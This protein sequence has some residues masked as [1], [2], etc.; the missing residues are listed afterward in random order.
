MTEW[1]LD[2]A[3]PRA[4]DQLG[5]YEAENVVEDGVGLFEM[6]KVPDFRHHDTLKTIRER[7]LHAFAKLGGDAA[8]VCPM[9]IERRDRNWA[10]RESLESLRCRVGW[11]GEQLPII[12]QSLREDAGLGK[13]LVE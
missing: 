9:K 13:G 1:F 10:S 8:V 2:R 4:R 6:E 12:G 7:R 3:D 5:S 11:R